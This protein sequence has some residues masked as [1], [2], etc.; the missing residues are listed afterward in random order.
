[1]QRAAAATRAFESPPRDGGERRRKHGGTAAKMQRAAAAAR[2][3]ESPPRDGERRH[4]RSRHRRRGG[5]DGDGNGAADAAAPP[6]VEPGAAA[7]GER[8]PR[9]LPTALLHS[10]PPSDE[11]RLRAAAAAADGA[12]A[13]P[14]FDIDPEVGPGTATPSARVSP[15]AGVTF[16]GGDGADDGGGGG[17]GG[18]RSSTTEDILA[19]AAE[20]ARL[21]R[22]TKRQSAA[23]AAAADGGGA[24]G[25]VC[26]A[27]RLSAAAAQLKIAK[28]AAA[29]DGGGG[30]GGD[31]DGDGDGDGAGG[32]APEA[33]PLDYAMDAQG[34]FVLAAKPEAA[35]GSGGGAD[36]RRGSGWL[37]LKGAVHDQNVGENAME[38]L[39][40][41]HKEPTN[42]VRRM[43]WR[44]AKTR[45]FNA[46]ILLTIG[47]NALVMAME[48]PRL[49]AATATLMGNL[50]LIFNVVFTIELVIKLVA[51]GCC[52]SQDAYFRSA[53]NA[54]D[55]LIVICGWLTIVLAALRL[56]ELG[57]VKL[58][59]LFR[60]LRP[61]RS[62]T[63]VPMLRNIINAIFAAVRDLGNNML[64]IMFF[65]AMFA[66]FYVSLLSSALR[67]RCRDDLTG[68]FVYPKGVVCG[69]RECPANS[70][71]VDAAASAANATSFLISEAPHA[72]K[73]DA[74]QGWH[75]PLW[76][77]PECVHASGLEPPRTSARLPPAAHRPPLP[78]SPQRYGV[79]SFDN[80]GFALLMVFQTWVGVGWTYVM[81]M[82]IVSNWV[83][84]QTPH[85][86][87]HIPLPQ[88]HGDRR[89][90]PRVRGLL[91]AELHHRRADAPQPGDRRAGVVVWRGGREAE[92]G[93]GAEE[94]AAGNREGAEEEEGR[95]GGDDGCRRRR[96]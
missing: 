13:S 85:L 64:L 78:H 19:M 92:G 84:P 95:G 94:E 11:R 29:A 18:E 68:A 63:V 83:T 87:R 89:E 69:A 60:V 15:K 36:G 9:L 47:A 34:N 88:V 73:V 24:R 20:R 42:F 21:K 22:E 46:V 96:Q 76:A 16:D 70:T 80:V 54:L 75:N 10:P 4:H 32:A 58:L 49:P 5:A 44:L 25:S 71:C 31:G 93:G 52:A 6:A 23:A 3:F 7:A 81:Y 35:G 30:G 37:A 59:R 14:Q 74:Y 12:D 1:M 8:S 61:L 67:R 62:M 56:D 82:V 66:I 51:F 28:D 45:G 17:G 86:T 79:V 38:A 57:S 33:D 43:C 27:S 65:L 90:R 55:C 77:N 72:F 41:G 39:Q 91:H 26:R 40:Q 53:W 50:E 48:V 2:A